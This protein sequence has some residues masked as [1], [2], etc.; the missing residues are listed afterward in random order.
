MDIQ[1][2]DNLS[3]DKEMDYL[4]AEIQ[5]T[6]TS[7]VHCTGTQETAGA[8]QPTP[9][10]SRKQEISGLCWIFATRSN[11]EILCTCTCRGYLPAFAWW[12]RSTSNFRN[13][14]KRTDL[15]TC[16]VYTVQVACYKKHWPWFQPWMY[17]DNRSPVLCS[18]AYSSSLSDG[19]EKRVATCH[20]N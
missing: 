13:R 20:C 18:G 1:G 14:L 10:I 17:K 12:Q 4:S 19:G 9:W 7:S 16:V 11:L 5:E 15:S 2:I 3:P 8:I 6:E